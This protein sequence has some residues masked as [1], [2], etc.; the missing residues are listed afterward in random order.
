MANSFPEVTVSL[1]HVTEGEKWS[2]NSAQKS[3]QCSFQALVR[4][5]FFLTSL[6]TF[7]HPTSALIA[8]WW[9]GISCSLTLCNNLWFNPHTLTRTESALWLP[10]TPPLDEVIISGRVHASIAHSAQELP[11][12]T[13]HCLHTSVTRCSS[14]ETQQLHQSPMHIKKKDLTERIA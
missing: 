5:P 8:G 9:R 7:L 2:S 6:Q 3:P 1:Q 14:M 10:P 13:C 11:I 4:K 12:H